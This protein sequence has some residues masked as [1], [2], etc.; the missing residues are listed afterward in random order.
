VM[1]VAVKLVD[2]DESSCVRK[3]LRDVSSAGW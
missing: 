3:I 1:V 2:D